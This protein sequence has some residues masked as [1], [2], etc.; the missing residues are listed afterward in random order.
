MNQQNDEHFGDALA[1]PDEVLQAPHEEIAPQKDFS[2]PIQ[3][4]PVTVE[5]PVEET[6]APSSGARIGRAAQVV[7]GIVDN[8]LLVSL[9]A[10]DNVVGF[11]VE[12]GHALVIVDDD[13]PVGIGWTYDADASEFTEPSAE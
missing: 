2:G 11:E 7:D 13:S 3:G 1:S 10:E 4:F 6:V 12:E 8:I 5:D 9:D